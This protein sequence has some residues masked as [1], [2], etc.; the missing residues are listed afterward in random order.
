M[1]LSEQWLREWVNPDLS[2]EALV[3][4][5]TMAG[6]EVDGTEPVAGTFTGVVVAEIV[7]IEQHPDADK[8]RVCQ[9]STGSETFQVVCGA[10]NAAAGLKIPFATVG[11]VL[12][13]DTPKGFKIKKAKLRGVE[14][15]GMLC[16]EQELGMSDNSEGLMELPVDATLGMNIREYLNLNDT[17]IEVDLTPNRA[18][19]LSVRGIARDVGVL[20]KVA[21]TEVEVAPVAATIDDTFPVEVI[22]DED[23]PRYVGRVI[24][25][26]DVSKPT[27]LWMQEK[28]RRSGLRSIDAIVDITNY[29]LLE[30]GQPL[31][32]FDLNLLKGG[33]KVRLAEQAEKII[34]LDGQ[35]IE[36]NA[37]SLVIADH[38]KPVALAGIMGGEATAVN[39]Q[40]KDIFLESA[41]FAP[42]RMAGRARAYGLHTDSSHRFERGVD[43]QLQAQ[44]AERATQLMLEIVGGEAGPLIEVSN[45]QHLPVAAKVELRQARIE[46]LLGLR[47]E[48]AEVTDILT[49]LGL[50]VDKTAEGWSVLS[51]SWRFDI[52]IEADLLEELARVYGYNRLPV[53]H[54]HADISLKPK[55]ETV[56][57]IRAIRQQL[58]ASGYQEAITYSFVEP[59]IQQIVCPG[60][61]TV[62]LSNPIS[63][64][65]SVMRTSLWPGLLCALLHNLNR[66]QNRVRLFES[67]LT[68]IPD[69]SGLPKQEAM[70]AGVITGRR[71]PESWNENGDNVDFYD[72]KGDLESVLA[73]SGDASAIEFKQGQ[74]AALHPGQTA[75]IVRNGEKIGY[76]GAIHPEIQKKLGLS[77][78]AYLFEVNLSA[79]TKKTL[80]EF[81]ELSKYPEVRRD[82]AIVIGR[83]IEANTV[84]KAVKTASG[85]YLR[86]LRLFDVYEG[87][88]I[89]PKRKSLAL[90][91]TFQH[92]SRT[93]NEDEINTT[94]DKV[95]AVLEADFGATL[96]N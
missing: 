47:M 3:E 76:L 11:A 68:F 61:Q 56:T 50:D 31:H 54:I 32:A 18:D 13:G 15:F 72:L 45:E 60:E 91:L 73:L 75:E 4:Q 63:A 46:K 1:K 34:L 58:I 39:D 77:Q 87:K 40:T 79:I 9:V 36:L 37:G 44:A 94:I 52:A 25:N 88:G 28:L 90:G 2:T 12:P 62:A 41:F 70:L 19:C 59:K 95:V 6:L 16:A 17:I 20:N 30:L 69:G 38:E 42:V 55:T 71:Q 27:P 48:D 64:D 57:G 67:G 78:V 93:L 84:L 49:R 53:T 82:L 89:D 5:I 83:E 33:I 21:V 85:S 80:P 51:P 92:S 22:A 81:T 43:Y 10:P 65:M 26:V 66:Q 74:H 7:A 86:N 24:R 29:I 14:S 35:E 8:L 96:R 23:C